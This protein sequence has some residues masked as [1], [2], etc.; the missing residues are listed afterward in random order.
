MDPRCV[1]A[2]A[3][4]DKQRRQINRRVFAAVDMEMIPLRNL[5]I[6]CEELQA[7]FIRSLI[8]TRNTKAM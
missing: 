5:G 3:N 7:E 2:P 1:C 4:D 8:I 6:G